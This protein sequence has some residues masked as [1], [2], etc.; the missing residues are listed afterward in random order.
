MALSEGGRLTRYCPHPDRLRCRRLNDASHRLRSS[1]LPGRA[2]I[3]RGQQV[4]R[5]GE[6]KQTRLDGVPDCLGVG[7]SSQGLPDNRLHRC[8]GIFHAMIQLVDHH[9][10]LGLLL[11]LLGEVHERGEMLHNIT[12]LVQDRADEDGGPEYAAILAAVA[13]FRTVVGAAVER[14]LDLRQRLWIS[15]ARHEE[16]ETVAEDLFAVVSGQRKKGVIGKND[17]MAGFLCVREYHRHSCRFSG[18]HE[19]AEVLPEALDF[20]F[21]NFLLFGFIRYFRHMAAQFGI[22]AR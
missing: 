4:M 20:S 10:G 11:L 1:A 13:D 15:A 2:R 6:R 8:E 22:C 5:P 12:A 16:I 14:D 3:S 19:R 18:H 9:C 7:I 21:G 17:R